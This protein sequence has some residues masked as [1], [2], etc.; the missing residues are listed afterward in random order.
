MSAS[1]FW[2]RNSA[3][4]YSVASWLNCRTPAIFCRRSSSAGSGEA[5]PAMEICSW[6]WSF[7]YSSMSAFCV[8]F[9]MAISFARW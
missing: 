6:N 8:S 2:K 4:R 7:L 5:P 3:I 9:S 1:S